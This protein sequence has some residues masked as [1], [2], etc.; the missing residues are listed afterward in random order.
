MT[1]DEIMKI[2]AEKNVN[3]FR[4]QF[5]DIF[6]AMKNIAIPRSQIEKALD[7]RIMFDGSSIEGFVR[8]NESDMH[9]KPDYNTFVV[10]PWRS[11]DGYNAARIIC[12]VYKPDGT[13]FVGCP[14]NNLKR[15]L[16]DAKA[17]GYTMN[18]GTECEFFLFRRD[19]KGL[20]TTITDDVTG[21]FD[22]EPDDTGIDCR[23]KIIQTLEAMG[24]EVEASH[25]EGAEGQHEINFK[26][27]DALTAADNTVT[28][29]WVVR[30]IARDFNLHATFMP[31]PVFGVNGSGMHTNQSLFDLDG[32]NA[33]FD[34]QDPLQL[35]EVAYK[36]IAGILKNARGFCGISNPLVNSYK[37]LVA[38]YE[39]PVYVA[40]SASNRSV[41]VRIPASRG[42][43]T[44]TEVRSPDPTCNPYLTFAMMLN[45]GLDG[46]KNDLPVP[47]PI[48]ADIF[49]LTVQEKIDAG[50]HSL[51][52]SLHEAIQELKA[53]PIAEEALG[54]H[55]LEKYIEGKEKEW[56]SFRTA[57]TDWELNHYLSRY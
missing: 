14:R 20:A 56:D 24:F 4:L 48:N 43:G 34:E 5:V 1:R 26:Y 23:R 47:A 13:P 38:G 8:I 40:W 32:G 25:H 12:D 49:E 44:R 29:K 41:L 53:S 42:M 6:G 19:E 3:F 55:I 27:A 10:L 31:K 2:I 15:V 50:I 45:A 9:L 51:P 37:R 33:F 11:K 35:S 7:G 30:S 57:V 46:I 16:A 39:A 21:Y 36:Y 54:P 18:V 17:L 52:A 22:V 28:F